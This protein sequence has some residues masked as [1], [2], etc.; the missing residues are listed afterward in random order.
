MTLPRSDAVTRYLALR[1]SLRAAWA[2][3]GPGE[4]GLDEAAFLRLLV[5]AA[6]GVTLAGP[7]AAR[8]LASLGETDGAAAAAAHSGLRPFVVHVGGPG[9]ELPAGWAAAARSG[10]LRRI[11]DVPAGTAALLCLSPL[12]L[13]L[14]FRKDH[15]LLGLA[16]R[17]ADE[18]LDDPL[19]DPLRLL[20]EVARRDRE[21]VRMRLAGER[22]QADLRGE[23][24]RIEATRSWRVTA[25][26]RRLEALRGALARWLRPSPAGADGQRSGPSVL[27]IED[28][29]PLARLGAGFPRSAQLVGALDRLGCRLAVFATAAQVEALEEARRALPRACELHVGAGREGLRALL[30]RRRFDMVM[31]CRPHNLALVAGLRLEEPGLLGTARLVYDAE[32]VFALREMRRAEALG[33]A[34]APDGL[35]PELHA[36]AAADEVVAVTPAERQLFAD[37]GHPRVRLL[38]LGVAPRPGEAPFAARRDLLFVGPCDTPGSPNEDG[39]RWLAG[40]VMPRLARQVDG[41]RVQ[42]A[43]KCLPQHRELAASAGLSLLGPLDDLTP[44]Y[45]YARVFVA[46]TRFAAGLPLK[47][48]EAASRGVPVVATRLVADL[49]GWSHGVELMAADGPEGFAAHCRAL[50]EDEQ[51]WCRLRAA[52]LE[53]VRHEHS[54]QAFEAAVASLLAADGR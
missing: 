31:A 19:L 43:G 36:A 42:V 3:A 47:V 7:G 26:L 15:P 4:P 52:A 44:H 17:L 23:V 25:P 2:D 10:S 51:L 48:L 16:Q 49:L 32:A 18:V 46:P 28:Q 38:G 22:A 27:V 9:L 33:L 45:D 53:R 8:I 35:G 34:A 12:W 37:A 29:P 40:E 54:P 20:E 1:E 21:I 41:V 39:L 24:R 13:F 6:P 5:E 14:A 50:L 11:D 30:R